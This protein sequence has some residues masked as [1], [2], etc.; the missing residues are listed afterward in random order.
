MS[1]P[2]TPIMVMRTDNGHCT[3]L[4]NFM[5]LTANDS[6]LQEPAL[7]QSS[8]SQSGFRDKKVSTFADQEFDAKNSKQS[9]DNANEMLPDLPGD[10]LL[11]STTVEQFETKNEESSSSLSS[12]DLNLQGMMLNG[13]CQA[14]IQ[15]SS[16]TTWAIFEEL[17]RN[18]WK[19]IL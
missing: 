14:N 18:D 7:R 10:D 9:C 6:E 12:P 17:H 8:V 11:M 13:R 15:E 4:S 2:K 5:E 3:Q 16:T 1:T 19:H